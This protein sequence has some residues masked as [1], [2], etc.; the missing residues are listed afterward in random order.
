MHVRSQKELVPTSPNL[1][2]P[3]FLLPE[4]ER[5]PHGGQGGEGEERGKEREGVRES[6][7]GE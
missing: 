6:D 3:S 4:V 2:M 1:V 5:T 7:E